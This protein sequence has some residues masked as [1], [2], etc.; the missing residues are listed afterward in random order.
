MFISMSVG[1]PRNIWGRL[2]EERKIFPLFIGLG[3]AVSLCKTGKAGAEFTQKYHL[4][5]DFQDK[6]DQTMASTSDSLE[7]IQ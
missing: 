1:N 4:A 6:L 5:T 3:C 7:C 2:K